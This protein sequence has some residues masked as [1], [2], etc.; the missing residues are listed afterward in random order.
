MTSATQPFGTHR[1][2]PAR[3]DLGVVDLEAQ[4]RGQQHA[5]RRDHP[6]QPGFAVG[7]LQDDDGQADIGPVLGGDAL[8][9]RA[10]LALGARRGVAANLPVVVHGADRA[11]AQPRPQIGPRT[12]T[13]GQ[14]NLPHQ[15]GGGVPGG[16][17]Q[18]CP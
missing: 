10:L 8:D 18:V 7:G 2:K 12:A 1:T 11:L 5:G 13:S 14:R 3:P 6:H 16:I 9:Q 15:P 4:P 17:G